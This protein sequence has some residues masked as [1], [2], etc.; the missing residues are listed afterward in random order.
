MKRSNKDV[1]VSPVLVP[2]MPVVRVIPASPD[3]NIMGVSRALYQGSIAVNLS[4]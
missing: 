1:E 2:E 4:S 3:V